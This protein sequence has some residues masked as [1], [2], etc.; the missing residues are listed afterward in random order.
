M[1]KPYRTS[2]LGNLHTPPQVEQN[3]T[4]EP[5]GSEKDSRAASRPTPSPAASGSSRQPAAAD[6]KKGGQQ[7]PAGYSRIGIY[8][9][10]PIFDDAKSAY[11]LSQRHR[12]TPE[13]S[14]TFAE[15]VDR[16]IESHNARTPGQRA[17]VAEQLGEDTRRTSQATSNRM[18][19]ISTQTLEAAQE[20]M[21]ADLATGRAISRSAYIVEA[22]RDGI[23]KERDAN[24]GVLPPA[25]VRLPNGF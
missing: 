13:W 11:V 14:R 10:K 22:I 16:Q 8:M 21:S 3:P 9:H 2:A 12:G 1:T 25:P 5:G 19:L 18:F 6:P 17:A 15:W 7:I 20:A 23:K 24:G 4:S